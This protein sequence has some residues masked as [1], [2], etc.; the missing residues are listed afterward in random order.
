[1]DVIL[2]ILIPFIW[3][4]QCEVVEAH[5]HSLL[6]HHSMKGD[7]SENI[8]YLNRTQLLNESLLTVSC[9]LTMNSYFSKYASFFEC[10]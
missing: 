2:A 7:L 8:N 1:M 6:S 4:M 3:I 5:D 10:S 9:L